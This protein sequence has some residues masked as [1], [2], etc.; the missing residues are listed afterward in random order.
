MEADSRILL[1]GVT[2]MVGSAVFRLLSEKG[3]SRVLAPRRAELELRD[4]AAVFRYFE[5]HKP[6]HVLMVAAKNGGIAAN[7]ADPVGFLDQNMRTTLNL[8]AACQ[9]YPTKKNLFLASSCVYPGQCP[10]PMREEHLLTGPLDPSN[11]GYALA[12]ITGLR[13]AVYQH[14]QHNIRTVC[15]VPCNMYGTGDDFDLGRSSV[16]S[17]LVRRFADAHEAGA[18]G[19]TL[20]GTGAARRELIHVDDVA[21]AILFFMEHVE[22]P[23]HINLGTGADITIKALAHLIASKVGY[24]GEI[25]WDA[26]KPDGMLRKCLDVTRLRSMGFAATVTLEEGITRTIGEYRKRKA[27]GTVT[28]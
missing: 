2:G 18:P 27:E 24:Q 25:R 12:K 1:T 20:W 15:P 17:A 6:E 8:Y 11:E 22:T 26:S 5:R 16:L 19:I 21:R 7:M 14:R 13:L 23:E 4:Q 3:Y 9:R 10:Q 28:A